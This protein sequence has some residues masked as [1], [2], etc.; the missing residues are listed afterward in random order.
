MK[1]R[2]LYCSLSIWMQQCRWMGQLV[3][4]RNDEKTD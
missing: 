3:V 1:K 4:L 2:P